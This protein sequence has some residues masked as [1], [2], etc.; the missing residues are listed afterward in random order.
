MGMT[1]LASDMVELDLGMES[2]PLFT[3][4]TGTAVLIGGLR[5]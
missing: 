2:T 4:I 5:Y 1:E 3:E